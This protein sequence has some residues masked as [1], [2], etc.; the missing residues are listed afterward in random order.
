[1]MSPAK[2]PPNTIKKLL[3]PNSRGQYIVFLLPL[4][5]SPIDLFTSTTPIKVV[6]NNIKG[7]VIAPRSFA[8]SH[9]EPPL[10][11]LI[12]RPASSLN[13]LALVRIHESPSEFA[14]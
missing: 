12:L 10:C 7:S 8:Y 14:P 2:P 6:V 1:M 13:L 9:R 5:C 3:S 4:F 11:A